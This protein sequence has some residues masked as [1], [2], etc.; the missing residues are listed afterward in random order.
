MPLWEAGSILYIRSV[1]LRSRKSGAGARYHIGMM[2]FW[3]RRKNA[4]GKDGGSS[5]ST[6]ADT[7]FCGLASYLVSRILYFVPAGRGDWV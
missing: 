1:C 4:L 5:D 3:K 6:P 7:R 2:K